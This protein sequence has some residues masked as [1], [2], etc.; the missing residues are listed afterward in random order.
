MKPGDARAPGFVADHRCQ[1][2]EPRDDFR[3]IAPGRADEE[4]RDAALDDPARVAPDLAGIVRHQVEAAAA[5]H[6]H[7]DEAGRAVSPAAIDHRVVVGWNRRRA[8]AQFDD[9]SAIHE[10]RAALDPLRGDE[11]DVRDRDLAVHRIH[12]PPNAL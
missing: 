5:V 7:V 8:G 11:A 1:R 4:R 6:V 2:L 12:W 9:A 3:V 10:H